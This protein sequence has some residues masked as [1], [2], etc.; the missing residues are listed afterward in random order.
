VPDDIWLPVRRRWAAL[1]PLVL[2]PGGPRER[3]VR[4]RRR[5]N[6]FATPD[7]AMAVTGMRGT[8]KSTLLKAIRGR[9]LFGDYPLGEESPDAE[10][11]RFVA[12]TEHGSKQVK[13]VV[14]PGQKDSA[15]G[16]RTLR[17]YF[18]NGRSPDGVVHVVSWGYSTIW[19]STAEQVAI[20][21]TATGDAPEGVDPDVARTREYNRKGELDDFRQTCALLK[22]SWRGTRKRLWLVIA[23]AKVDLFQN[24]ESLRQAGR[25]Y[26][27]AEQPKDDSPFARELRALVNHLGEE[28]FGTAERP[29]IAVVPLVSFPED[30]PVGESVV[31]STGKPDVI[32]VLLTTFINTLWEFSGDDRA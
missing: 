28:R 15:Q 18:R 7:V 14:V 30:Y 3:K 4:F 12:V 16:E 8:G 29:R 13:S 2:R 26:L 5:W 21:S 19:D 23:V 27:P 25:Y 22:E 9:L 1:T 20:A 6:F 24:A 17:K 10:S 11:D 31:Q 32:S